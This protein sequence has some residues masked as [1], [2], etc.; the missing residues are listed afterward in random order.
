LICWY[1]GLNAGVALLL[2]VKLESGVLTGK[3]S[4]AKVGVAFISID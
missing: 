1:S 3:M 4:L 2:T